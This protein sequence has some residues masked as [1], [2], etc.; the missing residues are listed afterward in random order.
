MI[1]TGAG[2]QRNGDSLWRRGIVTAP[3]YFF[4]IVRRTSLVKFARRWENS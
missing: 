2:P 1:L 4:R 3:A